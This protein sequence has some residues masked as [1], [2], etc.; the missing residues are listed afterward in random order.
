[1]TAG[2]CFQYLEDSDEDDDGDE[3]TLILHMETKATSDQDQFS[4]A[5]LS[6]PFCDYRHNYQ[7]R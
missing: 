1:M 4:Y 7:P 3:I 6:L 5:G 2:K